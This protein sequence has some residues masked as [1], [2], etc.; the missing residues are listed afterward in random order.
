MMQ[1]LASFMLLLVILI[2]TLLVSFGGSFS[3]EAVAAMGAEE[4][5]A[6]SIVQASAETPVSVQ[7][8]LSNCPDDDC[9]DPFQQCF[10]CH[11]GH[12]SVMIHSSSMLCVPLE[13]NPLWNSPEVI[14]VSVDLPGPVR[15]PSA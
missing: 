12:C 15:P 6:T 1:K 8:P 5:S 11:C 7:V 4:V 9:K 14:Y 13:S 3:T 2:N 10:H